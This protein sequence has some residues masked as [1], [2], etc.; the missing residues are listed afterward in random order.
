MIMS[1]PLTITLLLFTKLIYKLILLAKIN[2]KGLS[3]NQLLKLV[4]F[5]IIV[6]AQ[7]SAYSQNKPNTG[8]L[9]NGNEITRLANV[10]SQTIKKCHNNPNGWSA[11]NYA[12]EI[13]EFETALVLAEQAGTGNINQKDP[14]MPGSPQK[15]NALERLIYEAW[16]TQNNI[17]TGLTPI[18]L[19]VIYTLLE[20]GISVKGEPV[21]SPLIGACRFGIDNLIIKFIDMGV[22]V[23][24]SEG[25]SLY[26]VLQRGDLKMSKYLIKRGANIHL[27]KQLNAAIESKNQK[28]VS[29]LLDLGVEINDSNYVR[30]ALNLVEEEMI[31]IKTHMNYPLP[32]L[33]MLCYL[34]GQDADPNYSQKHPKIPFEGNDGC[35]LWFALH[36]PDKTIGQFVYKRTVIELLSKYGAT[37]PRS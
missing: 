6:S 15:I 33:D 29:L 28:L 23:N 8:P 24:A 21:F 4:S 35:S 17:E 31:Q 22:D 7:T 37:L 36:M 18:Q 32:A 2:S 5:I 30:Y 14:F 12:I 19:K 16:T 13:K 3:M 27:R 20:R 34:L 26:F 1:I 10:H 9:L 11:L 25:I